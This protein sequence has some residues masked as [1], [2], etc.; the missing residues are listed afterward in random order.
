MNLTRESIKAAEALLDDADS[1][2]NEVGIRAGDYPEIDEFIN[3]FLIRHNIWG[4][5][6]EVRIRFTIP[7]KP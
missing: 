3:W 5:I 2:R 7:V 4:T 1:V 6:R